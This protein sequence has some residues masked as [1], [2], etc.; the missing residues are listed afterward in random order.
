MVLKSSR[1]RELRALW[2]DILTKPIHEQAAH[3]DGLTKRLAPDPAFSV[4]QLGRLRAPENATAVANIAYM[5]LHSAHRDAWRLVH[6]AMASRAALQ[7]NE[8]AP[9]TVT[10]S[11][12]TP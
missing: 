9:T 7:T 1:L 11:T 2:P 6:G 8:P 3:A 10:S 12:S 5:A 4:M